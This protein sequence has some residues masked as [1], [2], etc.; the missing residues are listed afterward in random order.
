MINTQNIEQGI[1]TKDK[2][3]IRNSASGI[4]KVAKEMEAVF[5]NELLKV[6]RET[7]ESI[8]SDNK[9]FGNET[10]MGLFDM[11]VSRVIADKGIGIQDTIVRWLERRPKEKI[12]K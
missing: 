3:E 12:N 2:P 7:T 11:E 5:V 10:Y 6:M 8:S 4:R 9:G 1:L